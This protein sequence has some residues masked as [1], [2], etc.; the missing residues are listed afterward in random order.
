MFL[1]PKNLILFFSVIVGTAFFFNPF[2]ISAVADER[3]PDHLSIFPQPRPSGIEHTHAVVRQDFR[4]AFDTHFMRVQDE[5]PQDSQEAFCDPEKDIRTDARI[6]DA[7]IMLISL[8][9]HGLFRQGSGTII[10]NSGDG[11]GHRVLTASHVVHDTLSNA[12]GDDGPLYRVLAFSAEGTLLAELAPVLAG[13]VA[14]RDRENDT[15]MVLDDVAVL[16]PVQLHVDPDDWNSRGLDIASHQ[17]D[18]IMALF[19]PRMASALEQGMS[20]AAVL[21]TDAQ[22]IGVLSY[23]IHEASEPFVDRP[24]TV[25]EDRFEALHRSRTLPDFWMNGIMNNVRQAGSRMRRDNVGYAPPI[26][27][28]E[29]R[30]ALGLPSDPPVLDENEGHFTMAGYPRM[31]CLSFVGQFVSREMP[32]VDASL[33]R[34][35]SFSN[36]GKSE[37]V[38][39]RLR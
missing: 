3:F 27:H 2:T 15:S 38:Y 19:Q 14:S 26:R 37:A 28:A 16:A 10:R 35:V 24:H 34:I 33:S 29:I 17:A 30:Q 5:I 21:N 22:V 1:S 13:D 39:S 4:R 6:A 31:T 20:G 18:S 7:S 23:T 36:F 9:S 32:T 8:Y 11:L 12:S 25:F